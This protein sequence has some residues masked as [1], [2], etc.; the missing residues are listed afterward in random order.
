MGLVRGIKKSQGAKEDSQ[1][2]KPLYDVAAGYNAMLDSLPDHVLDNAKKAFFYYNK[3]NLSTFKGNWFFPTY[4]G[5]L[6]LYKPVSEWSY[7][8]RQTLYVIRTRYLDKVKS[9]PTARKWEFWS[10]AEKSL[11]RQA[12]LCGR[13]SFKLAEVRG[14]SPPCIREEHKL[15]QSENELFKYLVLEQFFSQK[16]G[17]LLPKADRCDAKREGKVKDVNAQIYL[18]AQ[19][20]VTGNVRAVPVEELFSTKVEAYYNVVCQNYNDCD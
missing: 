20:E 8:E 2:S 4:A 13:V 5:G 16:L 11:L 1:K 15:E 9:W 7:R 17:K 10:L 6:G 14:V 3:N 18:K 19:K 12:P